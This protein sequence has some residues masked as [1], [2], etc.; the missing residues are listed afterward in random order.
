MIL[1]PQFGLQSTV[2]S[3][4]ELQKT[5]VQHQLKR[6]ISP[7]TSER[8]PICHMGNNVNMCS[9]GTPS[10][11]N[12]KD[13]WICAPELSKE[14]TSNL[15]ISHMQL[16]KNTYFLRDLPHHEKN[17]CCQKSS[18]IKQNTRLDYFICVSLQSSVIQ[19]HYKNKI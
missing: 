8:I 1:R 11:Q 17:N 15:T 14:G 9:F 10:T 7:N 13:N 3:R 2:D 6:V 4:E 16:C 18:K 19:K 5:K 12:Q